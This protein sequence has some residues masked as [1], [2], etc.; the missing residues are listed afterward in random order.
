MDQNPY[1]S[2]QS[3]GEP[4]NNGNSFAGWFRVSWLEIAIVAV[5]FTILYWFLLP[6][7]H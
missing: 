2:P 4:T 5:L 1:E 3:P 7:I 6:A